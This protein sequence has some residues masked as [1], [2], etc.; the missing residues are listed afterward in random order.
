MTPFRGNLVPGEDEGADSEEE[1]EGH[2]TPEELKMMQE[3]DET[4]KEQ[5]DFDEVID[6][7]P[8]LEP[9]PTLPW[10]PNIP[11]TEEQKAGLAYYATHPSDPLGKLDP[12]LKASVLHKKAEGVSPFW[13]SK[14]QRA[15]RTKEVRDFVLKFRRLEE[16]EKPMSIAIIGCPSAGKS[17]LINALLQEERCVVDA[18]DGTTT[19]AIVSDWCFREQPVKIIDTCGVL[20]GWK[21]PSDKGWFE[22]GMGTKRAI[23]RANV[24]VVCVNVLSKNRVPGTFPTIPSAF[25]LGLCA[26]VAEEGK[27]LVIALNKWDLVPEEEQAR[28]REEIL[29]RVHEKLS[30]IKG[31]PVVFISAKYNLNLSM[32]M[33][34]V[35]AVWKR[36]G[37]RLPT[38]KVNQWLQAW[39]IRWPPPWRHGQKCNVKYMT[40]TRSRPP[41][42]VMWTNTSSSDMPRNYLRQIENAMR[43]EFRIAGVPIRMIIRTTMMPKP[44]KRLKKSDI[45]RWK[46]MG[47]KQSEAVSKLNKK[48]VPI[49]RTTE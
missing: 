7:E 15:L 4:E 42:F 34:R 45:L 3:Q 25:E 29:S 6:E 23:R 37:A 49:L 28:F 46:R 2:L 47:P 8:E 18:A 14:P 43:D 21:Y 16:Q 24:V 38:M 40:Q 27:C 44:R 41:T 26:H 13:L 12:G 10:I 17:S 22:P 19:D 30:Q 32:L 33:T 1:Q 48:K 39:M 11:L 36:W 35:F 5:N 20:K 31:V 9:T